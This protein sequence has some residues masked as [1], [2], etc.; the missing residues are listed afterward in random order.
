[1][2]L[3][4]TNRMC[5][6]LF[7]L[8]LLHFFIVLHSFLS[9]FSFLEY[10]VIRFD[11]AYSYLSYKLK[12]VIDQINWIFYLTIVKTFNFRLNNQLII[13]QFKSHV[14]IE[15]CKLLY[16]LPKK[17]HLSRLWLLLT[18]S[19]NCDRHWNISPFKT[20]TIFCFYFLSMHYLVKPCCHRE[21]VL[22]IVLRE[23]TIQPPSRPFDSYIVH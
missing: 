5:R 2:S 23:Q 3:T 14:K 21:N 4:T 13:I 12:Y 22:K 16:C 9:Y 15:L 7:S 20:F 10:H 18:I 6:F 19:F 1:M 8:S 11:L 17:L